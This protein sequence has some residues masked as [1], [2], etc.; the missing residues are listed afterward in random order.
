MNISVHISRVTYLLGLSLLSLNL[1]AQY[2]CSN[3][4]FLQEVFTDVSVTSDVEYGNAFTYSGA[5]TIL[6]MDVYQP[7]G[8]AF[9][10]RPLIVFAHGGSFIFGNKTS[11]DIVT[12]CNKYTRLGY[13]CASI[14][15]RLGYENLIPN[16]TTATETVYRATSDMR[17][18]IR[19]FR[20][21][22]AT[23]NQFKIDTTNI[24][25][26]GVSAGAF[27]V[28]HL[29]YLDQPEE[30]PTAVDPVAFGGIEGL[31]GNDGYSSKVKAIVNLCGALGDTAWINAGD[32]P[33]LSMH[34]TNDDVVPYGSDIINVLGISLFEVDGSHSVA[35]RQTHI[36]V[37]N[38]FYTWPGQ[39]HVPFVNSTVYM[40]SVYMAMTPFLAN[41]LG[42]EVPNA[43]APKEMLAELAIWP[44][45]ASETI[46]LNSSDKL[47]QVQILNLQGKLVQSLNPANSTTSVSIDNLPNGMYFIRV[48]S[49]STWQT[50]KFIKN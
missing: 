2:D 17:A 41:Q 19:Y 7:T 33:C 4:R 8:D 5:A 39:A 11:S 34:G 16:A 31:S 24:F 46:Y 48:L 15:Y 23:A 38:E 21:D 14:D 30:I 36:G 40:D 18:A 12:L 32:T 50:R 3:D 43:I 26:T 29:A 37:Q 6:K 44:N 1:S 49:N 42:C 28:L 10:E 25:A 27:M 47:N 13:V 22:R 35:A 45:P 20:K 9:T